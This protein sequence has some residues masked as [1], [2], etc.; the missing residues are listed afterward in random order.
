MMPQAFFSPSQEHGAM[1]MQVISHVQYSKKIKKNPHLSEGH[2]IMWMK[3]SP[4]RHTDISRRGCFGWI[5]TD[6][7][8][9]SFFTAG[10]AGRGRGSRHV[11]EKVKH[12]GSHW[13]MNYVHRERDTLNI[14]Q[15]KLQKR[16]KKKI[17][18]LPDRDMLHFSY[19]WSSPWI[20]PLGLVPSASRPWHAPSGPRSPSAWRSAHHSLSSLPSPCW[21]GCL[22]AAATQENIFIVKTI[23]SVIMPCCLF[24]T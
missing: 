16:R 18:S 1:D 10:G 19:H 17:Q 13:C 2:G 8:G 22:T 15:T 20:G 5:Q 12:I 14:R 6:H 3:C 11:G 24:F 4:G 7:T 9:I 21:S 23:N